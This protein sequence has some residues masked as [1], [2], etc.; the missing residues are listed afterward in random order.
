MHNS[1]PIQSV[2]LLTVFNSTSILES[3]AFFSKDKATR[4]I[5]SKYATYKLHA[6]DYDDDVEVYMKSKTDGIILEQIKMSP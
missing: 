6:A 3:V 1:I 2:Y 4:H 5:A